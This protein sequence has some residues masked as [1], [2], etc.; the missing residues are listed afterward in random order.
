MKP[1][2]PLPNVLLCHLADIGSRV[3]CLRR[4]IC[5]I[6]PADG[7]AGYEELTKITLI[8]ERLE[9]GSFKPGLKVH[10]LRGSIVERKVD[11]VVAAVLGLND[12]WENRHLIPLLFQGRN[13]SQGLAD[14]CQAPVFLQLTAV[15]CRPFSDEAKGRAR[16]DGTDQH[17][18]VEVERRLEPLVLCVKV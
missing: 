14:L 10:G 5:A 13:L 2:P 4:D 6:R 1:A 8:A 16:V 17:L 11:S 3:E 18:A 15:Q 7:R 12:T 9:N